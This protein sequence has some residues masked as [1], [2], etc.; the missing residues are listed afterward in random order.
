[1]SIQYAPN[2][3]GY[4]GWP[5]AYPSPTPIVQQ[6]LAR[7]EVIRVHGEEGAKAYNLAPNSSIILMD[8]TEPVVWL[9]TTDG[10]GYP[11]VTGYD[12]TPKAIS[13]GNRQEVEESKEDDT[14]K[15]DVLN[16]LSSIER[17][18]ADNVKPDA[19]PAKQQYPNKQSNN[20][21]PANKGN[22]GNA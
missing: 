10:A 2:N 9:K 19:Q 11:T 16:R 12:I 14:F 6:P 1:M 7:T 21:T 8:E 4:N 5:G 17:M 22:G 20:A 18:L 3:Y 15:Q 13:A